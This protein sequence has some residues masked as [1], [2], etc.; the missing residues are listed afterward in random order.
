MPCHPR[1]ALEQTTDE[2]GTASCGAIEGE[3]SLSSVLGSMPVF[4]LSH[5]VYTSPDRRPQ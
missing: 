2:A 3:T 5:T 1:G 4:T